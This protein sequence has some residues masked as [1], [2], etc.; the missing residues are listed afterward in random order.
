LLERSL[1]SFEKT[2]SDL[3]VAEAAKAFGIAGRPKLLAS[4]A[5]T[6]IDRKVLRGPN[7][8]VP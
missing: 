2:V 7:K 3:V 4:S 5:T 1:A 8:T 6:V